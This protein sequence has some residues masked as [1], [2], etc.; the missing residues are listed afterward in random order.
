M[1]TARSFQIGFLNAWRARV[2]LSIF[3]R[4]TGHLVIYGSTPWRCCGLVLHRRHLSCLSRSVVSQIPTAILASPTG[5]LAFTIAHLP[6]SQ[7]T[8]EQFVLKCAELRDFLSPFSHNAKLFIGMD[9]NVR[10]PAALSEAVGP[11]TLGGS[12]GLRDV[13]LASM[14][15]SF[16]L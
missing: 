4:S 10:F 6:A 5:L 3:T 8:Q 14:A 16:G 2:S 13:C 7:Y 15:G 1:T 9:A 12:A 11:H